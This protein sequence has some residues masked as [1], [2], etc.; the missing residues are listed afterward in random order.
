MDSI[1]HFCSHHD[2]G[3]HLEDY[4][5]WHP[6]AMVLSVP[7]PTKETKFIIKTS[8]ACMPGSC[9]GQYRRVA[10]LEVE[11][12]VESVAMISERARGVVRV[13]ETW[14]RRNVGPIAKRGER[15][16][17]A[18]SRALMEAEELAEQLNNGKGSLYV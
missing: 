15:G 10:V 2:C 1:E 12:G 18:Y 8:A 9:W 5:P 11:A 4:C 7:A 3:L 6:E 17:C 14:E 13:V 16:R